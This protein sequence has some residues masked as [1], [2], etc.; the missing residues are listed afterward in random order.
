[1]YIDRIFKKKLIQC[2]NSYRK[3]KN[4]RDAYQVEKFKQIPLVNLTKAKSSTVI[5]YNKLITYENMLNYHIQDF[6][7]N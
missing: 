1:M 6:L 4:T 2:Y 3:S 7:N 5:N